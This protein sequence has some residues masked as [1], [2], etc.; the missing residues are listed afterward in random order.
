[1]NWKAVANWMKV[2]VGVEMIA[3]FIFLPSRPPLDV[4]LI[5]LAQY[6]IFFP[7]DASLIIGNL[8]K[9]QEAVVDMVTPDEPGKEK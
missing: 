5:C 8:K 7:V 4:V 6:A 2:I 3:L 9:T 1:M